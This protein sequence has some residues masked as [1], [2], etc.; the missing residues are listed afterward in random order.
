ML[1]NALSEELYSRTPG[2]TAPAYF[3]GPAYINGILARNA[4]GVNSK[5]VGEG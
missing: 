4:I 1:A 3:R 2:E 5:N